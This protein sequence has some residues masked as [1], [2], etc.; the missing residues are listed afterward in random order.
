[1][2]IGYPCINRS[3]GCTAN[4]TFRLASYSDELLIEK[5]A[6]NLACLQKILHFNRQEGFGFF[7]IS[8]DIVPFA[9]H[10]IC[11]LDW[12]AHFSDE[13]R[14]IGAFIRR[15]GMRVSMH[16]D[17]FVLLNA[18]KPDIVTRSIEELMYHCRVLDAMHLG[19]SAKIQIHV[20]GIYGDK[21]ASMDRFAAVYLDTPAE[22]R[23][24]LVIENDDRLYS[25]ADCL[26]IHK[27]CGIPIVFD[28]FHHRCLNTGEQLRDALAAAAATWS[29]RDGV[30]MVDYSEQ[31]PGGRRCAHSE[32][33][34]ERAFKAVLS[35]IGKIDCD[36]MLE[37]KD[38]EKSA[39]TARE[40]VL[41]RSNQTGC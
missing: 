22:L 14:R 15:H 33:I 19:P 40:I 38:K 10:P 37:I 28:I 27:R 21:Q 6:A 11:T 9:S 24:R 2:K 18:L 5:V 3:I 26:Q 36:I 7:R 39:Q 41:S 1:M 4:A 23:R 30:I 35:Q 16:P 31:A 8:S 34:T 17:Q 12:T 25:F 20:G 32:H 13:F 29:K